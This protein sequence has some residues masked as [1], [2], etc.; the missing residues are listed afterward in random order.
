MKIL[1]SIL[2]AVTMS[3]FITILGC[4]KVDEALDYALDFD[5]VFKNNQGWEITL[6]GTNSGV[7]TKAGTPMGNFTAGLGD[8]F[9]ADMV[10]ESETTWRGKVRANNGFSIWLGL[11]ATGYGT[12]TIKDNLLTVNT[13]AGENYSLIRVVD[14]NSGGGGSGTTIGATIVIDRDVTGDIY[15][16][17]V[18]SFEV[19]SG[20]K[21]MVVK[22][23]E[24]TAGYKNLAD[25]FVRKGSAPIVA[26]PTPPTNLPK[27]TWTTDYLSQTP[28]RGDK[29]CTIT[30]PSSGTWYAG[31]Y[32]YNSNFQSRLTVTIT[33]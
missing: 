26:G 11:D 33:K 3:I 28:N 32:G 14:T 7:Y 8:Q 20:V 4:T 18:E 2:F 5:G 16:L 24:P 21:T 19:P 25:L 10:R 13:N 31:L 6:D 1:K 30:N 15:K 29:I 17:K 23:T 27:Y 12:I 22:T 9:C